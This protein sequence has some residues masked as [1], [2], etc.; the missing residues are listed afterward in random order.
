MMQKHVT[1]AKRSKMLA[2][3]RRKNEEPQRIHIDKQRRE[4]NTKD[5]D[6]GE[7][8]INENLLMNKMN[9]NGYF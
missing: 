9:E 4:I 3:S 7:K 1:W 5:E 2:T 8:N 6:E